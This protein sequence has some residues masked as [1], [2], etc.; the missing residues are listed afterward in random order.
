MPV[1]RTVAHLL[2]DFDE[3]LKKASELEALATLI[4]KVLDGEKREV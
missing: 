3:L 4:R 1:T 2:L